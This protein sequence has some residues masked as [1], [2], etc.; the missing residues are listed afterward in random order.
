MTRAELLAFC[1]STLACVTHLGAGSYAVPTLKWLQGPFYDVFRK[2]LWDENLHK[3]KKRFACRDFAA[4]YR[5]T[6]IECWGASDG[7]VSED[8]GLSVGEIWF[9]PTPADPF[10]P[11]HGIVPAITDRGLLFIEPQNNTL[12]P[13]SDEQ[14]AS[15]FFLR[16]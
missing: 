6:A 8:D 2:R 1:P 13:M 10:D 5:A 14:F 16:F 3:W 12:W 15:R 7:V 9:D 4:L 11:N